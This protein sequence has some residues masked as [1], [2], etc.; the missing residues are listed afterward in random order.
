MGQCLKRDVGSRVDYFLSMG[1]HEACLDS[2]GK[3]AVE[4]EKRVVQERVCLGLG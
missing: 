3:D 4:T 2:D 1:K